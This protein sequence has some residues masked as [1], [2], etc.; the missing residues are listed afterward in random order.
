M[1]S[2]LGAAMP[3]LSRRLRGLVP[4]ACG[5]L[6]ACADGTNDRLFSGSGGSSGTGEG[7][8]GGLMI[9]LGDNDASL[10]LSVDG[11]PVGLVGGGSLD[12]AA[13]ATETR[14]G[15]QIP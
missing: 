9:N 15:E 2:W 10:G 13:C 11:A 14:Q 7:P 4:I 6:L 3:Y 5:A 8:D 1:L 12:D